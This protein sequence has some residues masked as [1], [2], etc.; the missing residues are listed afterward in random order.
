MTFA[1]HG[2][3]VFLTQVSCSRCGARRTHI[4]GRLDHGCSPQFRQAVGRNCAETRIAFRMWFAVSTIV[5][6]P[7]LSHTQYIHFRVSMQK[8]TSSEG[9]HNP[10][11]GESHRVHAR[12]TWATIQDSLLPQC[13]RRAKRVEQPST[14]SQLCLLVSPPP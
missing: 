9:Q 1:F 7:S 12:S 2:F 11:C 6:L 8:D 13:A 14:L 5:S 3:R 10:L 4:L